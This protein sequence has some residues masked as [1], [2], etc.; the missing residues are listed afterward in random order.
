MQ[1]ISYTLSIAGWSV[2]SS[3]DPRT[4]LIAV[5]VHR[6]LLSLSP[7]DS[8][9]VSVYAPPKPKAGL[10]EQVAGAAAQAVGLGAAAGPGFAVEVRGEEVKH[11]DAM[12]IQ[13]TVGDRAA[14]V[15]TAEVTALA[16]SLG[17]VRVH[18]QT[19]ARKLAATR[20]N[21]LYENRSMKQIV[22][23]VCSQAGVQMG[24]VDVGST[25]PYYVAHESMSALRHIGGLARREG[26]DAYFD[27]QNKLT[28]KKFNKTR[29]DYTF[30]YGIDILDLHLRNG[31]PGGD[32]VRVYGESPSSNTGSDTWHWLAKDLSPFQSE[33][34]DGNAV[35]AAADGA[36]RTKD[37]ADTW[38]AA[39]LGRLKDFA[40]IGQLTI[41]G[42]PQVT[43][44][45]AIEIK[46]VPRPE[47]NG[48]FKVVSVRHTFSKRDGYLTR[49]G[50]SGKGG[51]DEAGGLLGGLAGQLAGAV[52]L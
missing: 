18:G 36:I 41:L 23:D 25:Y 42:Q 11:G 20:L 24:E 13:L 46:D 33:A 34:G 49:I 40:S 16:S 10:L 38:A 2:D 45:D 4:E 28:L 51:M 22:S 27:A 5:D 31:Q 48:L 12:S 6:S 47:L 3:D 17:V 15:M 44:G 35:L 9:Q 52:G 26:L 50:F 1:T 39:R 8:C 30:L 32:R 7:E 43:L 19:G 29:G 37:A 14:T 21:Q